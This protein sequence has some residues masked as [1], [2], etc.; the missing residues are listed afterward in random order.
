[1]DCDAPLAL[2]VSAQQPTSIEEDARFHAA[3]LASDGDAG[4]AFQPA[5]YRWD[6]GDG[7]S[8][9]T[10]K[11]PDAAHV[12][13]NEEVRGPRKRVFTYLV[14]AEALDSSGGVLLTG[15]VDI[16]LRN[17]HE[18]LKASN[19][20][21]QPQVV[22]HPELDTEPDGSRVI[23]VVL[24]TLDDTETANLTSLEV[25]HVPCTPGPQPPS[26][27]HRPVADVFRASSVRPRGS[28]SGRLRWPIDCADQRMDR[29]RS[30]TSTFPSKE[31]HN[32][33]AWWWE[34]RSRCGSVSV[35]AKIDR[36]PCASAGERDVCTKRRRS[37]VSRRGSEGRAP[38]TLRPRSEHRRET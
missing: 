1:M 6:F 5:S 33:E 27:D 24:K 26:A 8:R 16:Y 37:A 11:G 38:F 29:R 36:S 31:L 15:V 7:S 18:E 2:W 25:R 4:A 35:S 20:R 3:A 34:E 21:L 17:R 23:E 32:R 28:I 13:P 22:Y 10:T 30:A 9:V 14:K 12:F 19:R